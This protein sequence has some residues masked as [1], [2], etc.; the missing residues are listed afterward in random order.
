MSQNSSETFYHESCHVV[1]V[2]YLHIWMF[3]YFCYGSL[4]LTLS[5]HTQL[6]ARLY[7]L[8]M[9]VMSVSCL[10]SADTA[11]HS[12]TTLHKKTVKFTEFKRIIYALGKKREVTKK[13]SNQCKSVAYNLSRCCRSCCCIYF[14]VCYMIINSW[15]PKR[16]FGFLPRMD[17]HVFASVSCWTFKRLKKGE[18]VECD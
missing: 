18:R 2:V 12:S 7:A 13:H 8:H 14:S 5:F 4:G 6:V 11:L 10:C 9:L 17:H 1:C 15:E 3:L 16:S